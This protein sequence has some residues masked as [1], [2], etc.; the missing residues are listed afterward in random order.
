MTASF[1]FYDL[2]TFGQDPRRTRIAQFAAQRTDQALNPVEDPVSFYVQPADDLLPSPVATLITGITPQQALS[3]G[4][5]ESDAM[6][7]IFEEMARPETCTLGW[8]TLRFDDEF[9][10]HGLFRNFFDPSEREWR[11]GNSRWDLLDVARLPGLV[12]AAEHAF[13]RLDVLV[14]NASTFYPTPVGEITPAQWDDLT[15]TNL[16][17]PLF[18]SQAAAPA[19]RL[20]RGLILNLV[21]IHALRPLKRHP[22]YCAAKAGLLMLTQ[23]LARELAPQ[24][25]VNA[26]APGPV[27][28]P[29]GPMDPD[30]Q[31]RILERTALK[32]IG[33]PEDVARA[34]LFF[35]KD[36]PYVTGQVLAV[37]GG[38]TVGGF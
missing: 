22:V 38:R 16:R 3:Q 12:A 26:I 21:D 25:R 4:V 33:S 11:G 10:R 9:I 32:R 1:L 31:A 18:L 19:L 15:G 13:G 29:E 37:D 5:P 17:A 20:R 14:N 36:A 24:V 35:V 27:M 8:N 34:A 28:W 2:E 7:R 30:L 23:S 6:A